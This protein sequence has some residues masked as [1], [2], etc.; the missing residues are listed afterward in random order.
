MTIWCFIAPSAIR[1]QK[2]GSDR[3]GQICIEDP[4]IKH[5]L[6]Q[7]PLLVRR[8]R[9]AV[10]RRRLSSFVPCTKYAVPKRAIAEV[11]IVMLFF[12]GVM[13]LMKAWR[14][15][16]PSP[17]PSVFPTELAVRQQVTDGPDEEI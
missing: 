5:E 3:A 16:D 12:Y 11:G 6:R 13:H 8:V 15:H 2:R 7:G 17:N 9:N 1:C 4:S 10:L 14:L